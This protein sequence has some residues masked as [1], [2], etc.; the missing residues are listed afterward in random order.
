MIYFYLFTFIY[1][2][3]NIEMIIKKLIDLSFLKQII[4]FI[5][6]KVNSFVFV[7]LLFVE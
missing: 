7:T 6:L 5:S 4:L 2:L 1:P 3:Y